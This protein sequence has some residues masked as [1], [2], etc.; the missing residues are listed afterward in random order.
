MDTKRLR[1]LPSRQQALVAVA[2]LLDGIDAAM[3]LESDSADGEK[4]KAAAE[5]LAGQRADLRVP[6]AGTVF[7]MA[8]EKL[9]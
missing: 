1:D 5:E 7:R 9:T 4:L 8:I 3:Y 6:L 2:V